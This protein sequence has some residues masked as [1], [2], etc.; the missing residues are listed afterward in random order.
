VQSIGGKT[1][2]IKEEA[3]RLKVIIAKKE[4]IATE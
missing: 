4:K 2:K 1:K 3:I